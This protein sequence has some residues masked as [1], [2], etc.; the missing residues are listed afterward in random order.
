[1]GLPKLYALITANPL[2]L[3]TSGIPLGSFGAVRPPDWL[4]LRGPRGRGMNWVCFVREDR[5][6]AIGPG[7][8]RVRDPGLRSRGVTPWGASL[9][10]RSGRLGTPRCAGCADRKIAESLEVSKTYFRAVGFVR[11]TVRRGY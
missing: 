3:S 1:M 9:G 2:P 11:R 5:A 10:R 7:C 4:C 6:F 8:C